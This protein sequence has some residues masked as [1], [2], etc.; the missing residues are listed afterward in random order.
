M[1]QIDKPSLHFNTVL[2]DGNNSSTTHTVGFQPD[3]SWIKQR[4]DDGYSHM[5]FD[6][7]RGATK[8]ISSNEQNAEATD[9]QTL[10]AFTGTGFTVGTSNLVNRSGDTYVGW[11]WKAGTGQ[12]SSNTD[13]SINTT[14]TSV[15]TTAGISICQY[16]GTGSAGTIGHG[17]GAVPKFMMIKE[18]NQGGRSWRVYHQNVGNAAIMYLNTNGASSGDG[19]AFNSTTPTS[20]VFSVGTSGGTNGSGSTYIAYV[21]AEKKGFS[22]F[23]EWTAN[24]STD[25][26]FLYTGFKPAFFIAKRT[27][28]T[29]N[30][31]MYDS[32]RDG[33]NIQNWRLAADNGGVE[34]LS[35]SNYIDILSNGIK[36]RSNQNSLNNHTGGMVYMAFAENPIVGSNNIPAVGR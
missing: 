30:W 31:H 23:G 19:Q 12:G 13:G 16:T 26:P 7:I 8:Y 21:F 25:G 4:E 2:W 1:A 34:D 36:I 33:Y 29:G 15:N 20:S 35:S 22:R 24:N 14:Y 9:S 6:A 28:S 11:N 3:F 18:T 27:G 32:K 17:L 10:T 5:L